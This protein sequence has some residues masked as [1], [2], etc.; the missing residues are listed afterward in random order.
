MSRSF[1][2]VDAKVAEA[3]FFLKSLMEAGSNF[4]KI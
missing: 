2:I 1:E 3:N 4:F